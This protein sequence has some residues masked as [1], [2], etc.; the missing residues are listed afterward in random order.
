MLRAQYTGDTNKNL[1][2]IRKH[3]TN[4]KLGTSISACLYSDGS[5]RVNAYT[6]KKQVDL[7]R[8]KVAV[9][10]IVK[11]SEVAVKKIS[12][13]STAEDVDSYPFPAWYT[14]TA[15]LEFGREAV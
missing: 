9:E 13:R 4:R 1:A 3:L 12:Y 11:D 6:S 7:G 15:I 8:F 2:T 5:V 14:R 10:A